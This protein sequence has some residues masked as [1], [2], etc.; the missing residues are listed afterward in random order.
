MAE[1]KPMTLES[2][3]EQYGRYPTID[4]WAAIIKHNAKTHGFNDHERHPAEFVTLIH[5]EASEVYEE[6]RKGNDPKMT[7]YS[8]GGK[9]EGIPSEIVDVI[10]R[11]IDMANYYDINIQEAMWEKMQYNKNRPY[12]HGKVL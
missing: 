6:F 12:M 1:Q 3:P 4:E 11:A 9:P 5:S 7:Y 8:H 10:I 2:D